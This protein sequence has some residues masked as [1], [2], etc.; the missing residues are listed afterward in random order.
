[1]SWLFVALDHGVGV[2][3][4]GLAAAWNADRDASAIGSANVEVD[5]GGEFL[6]TALELVA[7][8]LAVNVASSAVYD[9]VRRLVRD[10]RH[11]RDSSRT[12]ELT[13]MTTSAGDWV[14]VVRSRETAP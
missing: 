7:V 13:E 4:A 8:P 5:R 10:L 11:G 9:L 6:P 2:E 12:I 1:M 14:V 3:P